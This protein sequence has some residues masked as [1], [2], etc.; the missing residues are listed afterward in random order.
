MKD[1]DSQL[2]KSI[3]QII[4]EYLIP[5]IEKAPRDT[6]IYEMNWLIDLIESETDK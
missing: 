6:A 3:P 2:L 4:K 5:N 1:K